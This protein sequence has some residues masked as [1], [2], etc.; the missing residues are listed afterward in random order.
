MEEKTKIIDESGDRKYFTQI[1]N[2]IV[3]HSTAY[4]QSLYLIMKRLAGEHGS[5]FAS[6]NWLA[7]KMGIHRTTVPV[8]IKKLLR[9]KWIKEIE[10]KRVRGG[11]VK[12]FIIVDLWQLNIQEYESASETDRVGSGTLTDRSGALTDTGGA[13]TDT[14]KNYSN[15]YKEDIKKNP[16]LLHKNIKQTKATE[17]LKR[18][19]DLTRKAFENK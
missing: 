11:L 15:N 5:C 6:M 2:I 9:R 12:Q 16:F 18:V 7:Q 3:N 10:S 8:I 1:P 13:Q 4:E 17:N 19:Q 14:K